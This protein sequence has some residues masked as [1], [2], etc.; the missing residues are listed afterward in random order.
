MKP[1][2]TQA[3]VKELFDY[4]DG[5]LF[6]K[7][8]PAKCIQIGDIAGG[9]NGKRQPYYRVRVKKERYFVHKIVYLFHYGYMPEFVDHIDRNIQN[10]KIENLRPVTQ[11]QNQMNRD[12]LSNSKT[13][14]KNVFWHKNRKKW[15]VS[16]SVNKLRK[17]IGY[18][19]DIELAELVALESAN[20]YHQQYSYKGVL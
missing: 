4:R 11:S 13:G 16:I 17:T 3:D 15:M 7:I 6:W 14:I 10:N 2:L 20:K 1:S 9:T 12:V 19:K 18:F 8:K 5:V